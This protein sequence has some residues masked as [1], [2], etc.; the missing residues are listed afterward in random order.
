MTN[1]VSPPYEGSSF[2]NKTGIWKNAEDIIE[3]KEQ[4]K[5]KELIDVFTENK[6]FDE[7]KNNENIQ[8]NIENSFKNSNWSDEFFNL[9]NNI[10]NI[11]YK[12]NKILVSKILKI[13]KLKYS[14]DRLI[15]P[16]IYNQKI[17]LTNNKGIIY[18]FSFHD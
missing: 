14:K 2:D 18:I 9:N 13:S 6:L 3:K 12:N 17:I 11:S 8:I 1:W 10:P 15:R 4:I 7:E 16:L 5:D